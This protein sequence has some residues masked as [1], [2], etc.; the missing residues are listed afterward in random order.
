MNRFLDIIVPEY[1]CKEEFMKR[2]LHS[3]A[4]QKN[5]DFNEIGIIIV[6]D[7]S[8][9]KL[10]KGIFKNY[11]KLN[12]EYYLKDVNE[13]VGMTRQYGLD[14]STAQYVTFVDQDDELY[15]NDSLA[16]VINSLKANHQPYIVTQYIE[17]VLNVNNDVV[18]LVHDT[19]DGKEVLHGVFINRQ[20]LI[21]NNVRFVPG[22]RYHDDSY[23]RRVLIFLCP[24]NFIYVLTYNWKWNETSIVRRKREHSYLVE[25]FE[26]YFSALLNACRFAK[27]RNIPQGEYI[28]NAILGIFIVLNSKNF[29]KDELKELKEKYEKMLFEFIVEFNYEVELAR[30]KYDILY[31]DEYKMVQYES[32]TNDTLYDF[33]ERMQVAYPE[34]K[35]NSLDIERKLDIII[36]YYSNENSD[37]MIRRL[38]TSIN[39]QMSINKF[40]LGVIFVS[41]NSPV[42]ITKNIF[43]E[44]P[45]LN[46]SYYVKDKNEGQGLARQYGLE[47]SKAKYVTFVDQD[48]ILYGPYSISKVLDSLDKQKTDMLYTDFFRYDPSNGNRIIMN[49]ENLQCLHGLFLDR[50]KLIDGGYKFNE[51]IRMY[52]DTYFL[53]ITSRTLNPTYLNVPTYV[54]FINP[55][56]QSA[57]GNIDGQMIQKRFPEFFIANVDAIDFIKNKGFDVSQ[58]SKEIFYYL[59]YSRIKTIR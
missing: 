10:R 1:N 34:I 21:D 2:L 44:F 50:K 40:D 59:L 5:V 29:A 17:E 46:I 7:K 56:S 18:Q 33:I 57:L 27:Q 58:L 9:N 31:K 8:K 23:F 20:F 30:S 26:D 39:N 12:I 4:R 47:R 6:N 22:I 16:V 11:P 24:V 43:N 54:W 51:K 19:L 28:V 3:I 53:L 38:L 41:D 55:N 32:A 42:E 45:M 15:G 14:K 35:Y 52:E 49:Y 25:T 36:P 13:G 37:S 48:D